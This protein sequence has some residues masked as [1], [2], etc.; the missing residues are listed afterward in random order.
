MEEGCPQ[1]TLH[2]YCQTNCSLMEKRID[3]IQYILTIQA[4][5]TTGSRAITV[6]SEGRHGCNNV[7][8]A[9]K[10]RPPRV[11]KTGTTGTGFV[12]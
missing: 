11:T 8:A 3:E 9:Q 12:R 1:A 5:D 6:D 10:I 7:A 4:K 2:F